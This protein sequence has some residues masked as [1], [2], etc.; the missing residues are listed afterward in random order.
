MGLKMP[1]VNG[2]KMW[3]IVLVAVGVLAVLGAL[4]VWLWLEFDHDMRNP[5]ESGWMD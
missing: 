4:G 5:Q 3:V 2:R 1:G